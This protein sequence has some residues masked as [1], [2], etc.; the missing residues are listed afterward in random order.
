MLVGFKM[1]LYLLLGL[2]LSFSCLSLARGATISGG[3]RPSKAKVTF[4]EVSRH[5]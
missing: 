5:P 3:D 1:D 2:L 4:K